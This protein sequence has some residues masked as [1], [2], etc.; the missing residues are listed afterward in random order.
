MKRYL[1]WPVPTTKRR[2]ASGRVRCNPYVEGRWIGRF[3][4]LRSPIP[5][6]EV[7]AIP[8]STMSDARNYVGRGVVV[9]IGRAFDRNA[10]ALERVESIT[11]HY[12]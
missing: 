4:A 5:A 6:G 2:N 10:T 12:I 1:P 3:W 9:D 8:F 7:L 11:V